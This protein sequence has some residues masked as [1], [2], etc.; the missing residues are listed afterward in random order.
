VTL[1]SWL[2]EPPGDP[3][4]PQGGGSV[5]AAFMDGKFR[6]KKCTPG[7][8]DALCYFMLKQQDL[9]DTFVADNKLKPAFQNIVPYNLDIDTHYGTTFTQSFPGAFWTY[10]KNKYSHQTSLA[11]QSDIVDATLQFAYVVQYQKILCANLKSK[12]NYTKELTKMAHDVWESEYFQNTIR[13]VGDEQKWETFLDRHDSNLANREPE[14]FK[15]LFF[16]YTFENGQKRYSL[17]RQLTAH[18]SV[19]LETHDRSCRNR[20][21]INIEL[22]TSAIFFP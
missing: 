10:L 3:Q 1:G 16:S 14:Y 20:V 9:H 5:V 4:T 8:A 15:D 6:D 22:S 18:F 17:C 21:A 19:T 11:E 2:R 12:A 13:K 7:G